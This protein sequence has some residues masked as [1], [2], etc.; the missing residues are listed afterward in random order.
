MSNCNSPIRNFVSK[1][2][3]KEFLKTSSKNYDRPWFGQLMAGPQMLAYMLQIDYWIEKFK[4]E[5][6][7]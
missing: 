1:A 7:F 4:I 6:E 2:K 5:V 3:L